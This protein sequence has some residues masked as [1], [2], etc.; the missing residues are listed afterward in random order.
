M[1]FEKIRAVQADRGTQQAR[2]MAENFGFL[3][4]EE[5]GIPLL[6]VIVDRSALP[7]K[8]N[9]T[10]KALGGRVDASSRSYTRLL[11]PF[12]RLQQ[13]STA[14]PNLPLSTPFPVQPVYGLGTIVAESVPLAA[15]DGYQAGN[16]TGAGVRVAVVDLGFSNLSNAISQG[17]LPAG[18][19][20]GVHSV[21]F[22]GTGLESG[23]VHGTGVA[24]HVIDMAP[25]VELYC[26]R[27]SDRVDLEN[28]ADYIRSNNI[29]IANHSVAWVLASYYDDSG[30]I[31]GIIND[32]YDMDGIFWTVSSG[33]AARQH[34]RGNWLDA[35]D[36][37]L[38]EFSGGGEGMGLVDKSGTVT[39][40]LNWNQYGIN[41]K[42]NLDLY[43]YDKNNNAVATST[44]ANRFT[45]PAEAVNFTFQSSAAPYH[46]QVQRV[47][48]ST[49]NLDITLFS[50]DHNFEYPVAS[51][52][53]MDP[54]S[55]HGAFTVGAV[56]QTVWQNPSPAIRGYS[57]QGPSTDGRQKPDLVAPDGTAS[58]TY[59]V[60]SGT[61]F[62]APTTA[63][64]AALLLQET[65]TLNAVTLGNTLRNEA[66]DVGSA[67]LDPVYGA[68]KLQLPL[69]D[70]DG[71]GLSNVEEIQ[72]GTDALDA[73]TDDD[74]LSDFNEDRT[75]GTDP[76]DSDTDADGLNDFD[77]VV[78][79]GTDPLI[80]NRGDLA[81]RSAPDDRINAA[82]Y[83]V[84]N[85]LV[86]QVIPAT[87]T[88]LALGD[89][90]NNGSLDSGDLVLM[91]RIIQGQIP[92]P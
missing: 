35:D 61:S 12:P 59:G 30:L 53:L 57:S 20:D 5:R 22:T 41:N 82:D 17:E 45:D 37:N 24:E 50:F 7:A 1:L 70:S 26:L 16:L 85:R 55:A 77:E 8:L 58:L 81:P 48:G 25:G 32:S 28:A 51:S 79:Y 23:T 4:R 89:L 49:A 90:N 33:N 38:L 11:V 36:N 2:K 71:D 6:P 44:I 31:N 76:L 66:I 80:S 88:E 91:M 10:L 29:Q 84:L 21:D 39:V 74:G 47:S 69:I 73:D 15:A 18:A 54:A 62:S 14:F 63:G 19:C 83:L 46:V 65:P 43:V 75:H 87:E 68:G 72:L 86:S 40:F 64:T 52:S 13:L 42:T 92:M 9:A 3:V 34:W 56:N 27:V 60:S 78:T 67:G